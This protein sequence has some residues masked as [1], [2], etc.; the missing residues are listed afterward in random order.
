LAEKQGF[1]AWTAIG[2]GVGGLCRHA[3]EDAA[4]VIWYFMHVNTRARCPS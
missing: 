2:D 3:R 4:G 1:E